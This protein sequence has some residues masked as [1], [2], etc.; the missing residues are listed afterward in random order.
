[1]V[2]VTYPGV[3]VEELPAGVRRI[4]GVETSTAAFVGPVGAG[5]VH[6]PIH[7]HGLADF[8]RAF[9]SVAETDPMQLSV[10][11]FFANGGTDAIV[12]RVD[13]EDDAESSTL[14]GLQAL[15]GV[16]RFDLL[17]LPGLYGPTAPTSLSRIVSALEDA[18]RNCARRGAILLVDPLPD[19][20]TTD[21][22][23]SGP[24]SIRELTTTL[25]RENAVTFFPNLLVSTLNGPV[26]CG[27]AGAI[28]GVIA[29]T[30]RSRGIWK[31]P[32]G[33]EAT[34]AGT[35]GPAT[36][37]NTTGAAVLRDVA[38]NTI[39]DIPG[40]GIV[41]WGARL[42]AS[43]TRADPEWMYVHIRRLALFLE[44]SLEAG[45][46][47][48]VFEPNDEPVWT[49]VRQ[50]IEAFLGSQFRQGAFAGAKPDEA[51]FVACGRDTMTQDDIDSG[52]VN[53][54]VGF[55]PLHPAEF[56]ILRIR[57]CA[58]DDD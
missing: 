27:P 1:M 9:G 36:P 46:G 5:P 3:Y 2:R 52:I 56:V 39:R 26:A 53:I 21:D 16:E 11:L 58:T 44:H 25:A 42:L 51:Y 43:S 20:Q 12:V 45:L 57:H 34:I 7:V 15:D 32:A 13:A 35:L 49:S 30:D 24:T 19:W 48:V 8:E 17:C 10:Q 55:A 29:R 47:W 33:L 54:V 6:E 28:A 40:A 22:V 4:E 31:A 50:S 23:V 38:V 18:S 37:I 14:A 41:L